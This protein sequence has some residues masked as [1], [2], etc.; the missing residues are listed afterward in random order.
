MLNLHSDFLFYLKDTFL[1]LY[2]NISFFSGITWIYLQLPS[3]GL[4]L[5]VSDIISS[6]SVKIF[7]SQ[8]TDR[9]RSVPEESKKTRL[10]RP[11][12]NISCLELGS[13]LFSYWYWPKAGR[14]DELNPKCFRLPTLISC[15]G[16]HKSRFGFSPWFV[17]SWT[18]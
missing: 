15:C 11:T 5:E 4:D 12:D 7:S 6:F 3:Q 14:S 1:F 8:R 2:L 9:G 10:P 13:I 18:R 16:Y 17:L